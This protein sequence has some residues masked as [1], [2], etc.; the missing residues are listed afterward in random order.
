MRGS[1][2]FHDKFHSHAQIGISSQLSLE[3]HQLSIGH[4]NPKKRNQPNQMK[5]S[6][7]F[8]SLNDGN[9]QSLTHHTPLLKNIWRVVKTEASRA[10]YWMDATN[11]SPWFS[12]EQAIRKQ[13]NLKPSI[14]PFHWLMATNS[15][16]PI[17]HLHL[18]YLGIVTIRREYLNIQDKNIEPRVLIRVTIE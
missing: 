16:S 15:P 14:P 18:G 17:S 13:N 9:K 8:L 11:S 2:L 5:Q 4:K 12:R 1:G 10:F 3:L 7:A 6:E